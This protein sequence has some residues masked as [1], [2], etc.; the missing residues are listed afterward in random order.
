MKHSLNEG[1]QITK[2]TITP[3]MIN[4][5]ARIFIDRNQQKINRRSQKFLFKK[6]DGHF[7][8]K[9][10]TKLRSMEHDSQASIPIL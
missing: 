2:I 9:I 6:D 8:A 7:L 1:I 5:N 3:N 4:N 10:R